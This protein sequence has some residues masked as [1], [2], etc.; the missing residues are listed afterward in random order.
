VCQE[1]GRKSFIGEM[2]VDQKADKLFFFMKR[3][4]V[5]TIEASKRR[6]SLMEFSAK[7]SVLEFFLT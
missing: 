3:G 1:R 4:D 7:S 6:R 2:E 5:G